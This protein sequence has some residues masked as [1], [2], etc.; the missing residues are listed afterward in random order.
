MTLGPDHVYTREAPA[1]TEVQPDPNVGKAYETPV[2]GSDE[3]TVTVNVPAFCEVRTY[4]VVPLAPAL[5]RVPK[6]SVGVVGAE[7]STLAMPESAEVAWLP[8]LSVTR[9][10]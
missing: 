9:R 4:T 8:T 5:V 3:L 10:R 7:A 6:L 1:V 2:W